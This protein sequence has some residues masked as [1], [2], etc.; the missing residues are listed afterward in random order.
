[1]LEHIAAHHPIKVQLERCLHIGNA[2]R[3]RQIATLELKRKA[4][5][6]SSHTGNGP[7]TSI[8]LLLLCLK[9][10]ITRVPVHRRSNVPGTTTTYLHE[11][12]HDM[13]LAR[14]N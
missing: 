5:G 13:L 8:D 1:M 11:I 10:C 4:K 9:F 14:L 3:A 2:T 7:R 12:I 6:P